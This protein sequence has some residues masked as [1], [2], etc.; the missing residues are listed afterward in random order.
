M[1]PWIAL[2]LLLTLGALAFSSPIGRSPSESDS[3]EPAQLDPVI[4]GPHPDIFPGQEWTWAETP[5]ALGWSSEK[6][7]TARSV[8]E[9]IGSAAVMIIDNGVVV[10]GWGDLAL[11][12]FCHSMRKSLIS[13]LYG[14]YVDKE[15]IDPS[16]TLEQLGIDDTVPLTD[17]EKTATVSD[18]MRARSGIYIRAAGESQGMSDSRPERGS[19]APG[20]F[21]YYNNW[22]FNALG[23]IFD[24]ETGEESIYAAFQTQIAE[25][26]G[27]QDFRPEELSYS[28]EP[29]TVHPYYG[30]S[31]STRDL[32]RF[33]LLFLREGRWE[34]RQVV[35]ADWVHESTASHSE[36]GPESG[37]GY[38]WWT[39]SG[40]GLFPNVTIQTHSYYASG[41]GGHR[42]VVLPYRNLVIAHRVNTFLQ[43]EEVSEGEF[44]V[45]LWLILDAAGETEMGD[46]PFIDAAPGIQLNS[47]DLRLAIAGK[48]L[49]MIGG[50]SGII[51]VF[52][53]KQTISL[54]YNGETLATGTWYVANDMLY[55]D[56]PGTDDNGPL[57]AI[58]DG[59]TLRLY[60]LN[61]FLNATFEIIEEQTEDQEDSL[62]PDD[63]T[64]TEPAPSG[65]STA[66]M[67]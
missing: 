25:P 5:E 55:S 9:Q 47:K 34:D 45:L 54:V 37:Y 65:M 40:A 62:A 60:T 31:M 57:R 10:D 24:Q 52:D 4:D 50:A 1:K 7:A 27:M 19:H 2:I 64:G 14:I 36:T 17:V 35:P 42:V 39:G 12:Y 59:T 49:R 23:T 13:A 56:V 33:G 30:F 61:G 58:L 15:L 67:E 51:A 28:Y 6:L 29:Y 11:N 53:E 22:D 8:S 63:A 38:M 46:P 43:E 41:Y 20:T 3:K 21:W 44:G 32:A 48:A 18:L 16:K 26:I 66:S